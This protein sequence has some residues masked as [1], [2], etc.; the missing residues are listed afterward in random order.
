MGAFRQIIVDVFNVQLSSVVTNLNTILF[1]FFRSIKALSFH[2]FPTPMFSFS[3][4]MIDLRW[5]KVIDG[6]MYLS[7]L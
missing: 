4:S 5:S 1:G 3:S 2:S 7:S 6:L